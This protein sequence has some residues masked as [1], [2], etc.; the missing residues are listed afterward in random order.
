MVVDNLTL[1]SPENRFITP[2]G[3][4]AATL[5]GATADWQ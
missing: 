2:D 4:R 5:Y 1:N 3:Q